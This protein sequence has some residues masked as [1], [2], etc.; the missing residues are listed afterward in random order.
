MVTR[1]LVC[2]ASPWAYDACRKVAEQTEGY[3]AWRIVSA[4][5]E[6]PRKEAMR[7]LLSLLGS[8]QPD[9]VFVLHWHFKIPSWLLKTSQFVNLHATPLPYG[10]G[11]SPIENMIA[12]GHTKTVVTAHEMT[13]GIDAGPIYATSWSISL[14]GTRDDILGRLVEPSVELMRAIALLAITPKAQN[15]DEVVLF[16]R[17]SPEDR[18]TFWEGHNALYQF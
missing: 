9:I 17:L 5:P 13:D 15:E 3:V 14:A 6:T 2:A 8:W 11:G 4:L 16:E 7:S 12:R 18:K 1:A 10:R